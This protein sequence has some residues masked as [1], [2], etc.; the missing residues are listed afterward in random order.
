MGDIEYIQPNQIGYTKLSREQRINILKTERKYISR[1]L[2][3]VFLLAIVLFCL[4]MG[5]TSRNIEAISPVVMY[6]AFAI[7]SIRLTTH[8]KYTASAYG[9]VVKKDVIKQRV[10]AG[11]NYRYKRYIADPVHTDRPTV[12]QDFY[13]LTVKLADGRY[14][15]YVN[16]LREDFISFSE[17]D[18]VLVVCYGFNEIKGYV[19]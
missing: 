11:I 19:I 9:I 14:V 18:K 6:T 17:G 3:T 4:Y 7:T 15:R 5:I 8:V 13:Y 2:R 16:C 10:I 12:E 1:I